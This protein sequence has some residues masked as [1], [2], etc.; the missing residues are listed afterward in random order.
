[1]KEEGSIRKWIFEK[2][3]EDGNIVQQGRA[4]Y[5]G[6]TL[7]VQTQCKLNDEN[8]EVIHG[9]ILSHFLLMVYKI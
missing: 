6:G 3:S 1:M 7:C 5:I 9:T 8:L 4:L 2:E